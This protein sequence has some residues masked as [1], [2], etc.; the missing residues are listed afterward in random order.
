MFVG[1]IC[2]RPVFVFSLLLIDDI[3]VGRCVS[4]VVGCVVIGGCRC[5]VLLL[6]VCGCLLLFV[7]CC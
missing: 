3:V 5:R 7:L 2:C 1:V 4:F 6:F